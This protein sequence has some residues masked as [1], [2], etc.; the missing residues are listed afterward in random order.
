MDAIT[1]LTERLQGIMLD[2]LRQMPNFVIGVIVFWL[3]YL[4]SKQ[5]R[6]SVTYVLKRAGRSRSASLV[7]GRIARWLVVLI[8]LL[9]ALMIMLPSFNPAQLIDLLGISGVAIG[10]AFRDI[11]QNFLAGILL[12]L[13]EPFKIGDQI[14]VQNYEGTVEDIQ[15]RATLITTYDGRRVVIPNSNIFTESVIVNTAFTKRRTEYEVGIGYGD[16]MEA[17]KAVMLEAMMATDGVL[18]TPAPDV[19]AVGLAASAVS[20][21]ARWWTDS[22]RSQTLDIQDKVIIAIKNALRENGIDIPFPTQQVLFHDQTEDGD[23]DRARQREGWPAGKGEVPRPNRIGDKLVEAAGS[24]R[25][26]SNDDTS[27]K[28]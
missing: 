10:F 15:V 12:L 9:L 25:P 17:A 3:I 8:G 27:Q 13:T 20:L 23:G 18:Q 2:V 7:F 5:V 28:Q 11:L 16:G 24:L 21:R 22:R 6:A 26:R 1:A 14:I 4:L 19:I